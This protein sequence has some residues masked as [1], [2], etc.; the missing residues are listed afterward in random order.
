MV[1]RS[2]L[3]LLLLALVVESG[4]AFVSYS[5]PRP[6][7]THRC[8]SSAR[9]A[10]PPTMNL[11]DRFKRVAKANLNQIVTNL[12]DPEKVMNQA[13][14]DLN[15]DLVKIRQSYAEV[16]ASQKRLEK[17]KEAAD[18]LVGE[19]MGRAQLAVTK[20]DDELAREALSRKTQEADK[21][22]TLAAQMETQQTSLDSL[23][24]SMQALEA[25]ISEAK[26]TR[27][28]FIARARTAK[29]TSQV[30]DMLSGMGEESSMQA[31]DRMKEKVEQ[32][33]SKAEVSATL[34]GSSADLSMEAKFKALE[35]DNKVD[36]ELAMMKKQLTGAT[37]SAGELPGSTE[38]SSAAGSTSS[39]AVDDELSK[40]KQELEKEK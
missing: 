16:M 38:A 9:G 21:V 7:V 10:A 31:F 35:G 24:E 34:T 8:V 12:E 5:R 6:L 29:T 25:K 23:Y 37:E 18:K 13:V 3:L 14:E 17:Q 30:N 2:A 26:A 11:F 28:Q 15:K 19:W 40:L 4:S 32:L 39:G 33:E 20:G 36:D 1:S 22:E 27:E